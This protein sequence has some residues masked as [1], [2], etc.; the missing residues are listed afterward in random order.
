[1]ERH[2]LTSYLIGFV[3]AVI[4]TAIPF[5]LVY[6]HTLPTSRIMWII[7]GAAVLQIL[8]H[9]HF[10]LHINFTTTPRE[11]L[12]AIAFAHPDSQCVGIAHYLELPDEPGAAIARMLGYDPERVQGFAFVELGIDAPAIVFTLEVAEDKPRFD[13]AAIFLQGT[14]E[15]VLPG[16]GL[17]LADEQRRR[18]PPQL[19]RASEPEQIIPVP[20]NELLPDGAFDARAEMAGSLLPG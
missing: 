1:M 12:L 9:L 7:A 4:L 16:I 14:G 13:Q 10:F 2:G 3:L 20:Q 11:N 5:W 18:H 17:Q 6:T 8:V 19:E 15:D